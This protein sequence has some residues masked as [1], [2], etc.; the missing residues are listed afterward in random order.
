[1]RPGLAPWVAFASLLFVACSSPVPATLEFVDQSPA[2]PRLGEITTLRFRAVDSRGQPQAGT[3][4]SFSLQSEVP[5]VELSPE[6]GVTNAEDGIVSVQVVARGGRVASVVVVATAT[7]DGESK[8]AVSPVVSFA[9]TTSSARQFTFQCGSF[10]GPGS[11]LHHAIGAWDETRNLIAGVKVSCIAHVGDRNGDGIIGAQVSFLTEAGTIGPSAVSATDVVGNAEV[12]YKS[13]LPL[14]EDVQPV[15]FTWSPTKD[16]THTGEYVAPL[17]MHPFLWTEN[18]LA[19]YGTQIN[20]YERR[21]EPRRNDPI[22]PGKVNNPRDNLVSLIAITSGEEAYD[23]NNN[24]GQWDTGEEF[25]DLTEPFVDNNDNGTWD[26][27][28]RFVD[29]NGDGKWTGKNGRH[30]ASTLIWVQERILWTGWAHALDGPEVFRQ[31]RPLPT[32]DPTTFIVDHFGSQTVEFLVSDPWYNRIAQNSE[33]DG[34]NGGASGPVKVAPTLTGVALTYP[35]FKFESYRVQDIHEPPTD[36]GEQPPINSP[37][38]PWTVAPTC[39]YT[40]AQ[41]E[42]HSVVIVGPTVSGLVR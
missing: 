17:W 10:S 40:A 42:G 11:G 20:P 2:Q 1:M 15:D 5:G 34:C 18:P 30:D 22:R 37:P 35:S 6:E 36:G 27:H 9:G 7:G 4:V 28:E 38:A 39:Y 3:P 33:E 13:S 26:P 12:L 29:S 32:V 24:N 31:I 16:E 21:P 8:T 14:P 25:E 23:D 41:L 19:S